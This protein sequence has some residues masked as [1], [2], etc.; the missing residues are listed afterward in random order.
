MGMSLGFGLGVCFVGQ[1]D[2]EVPSPTGQWIL[3]TGTWADLGQWD[4][5]DT[6]NDGV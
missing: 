6:W 1:S 2:G 4:D 5:I 3:I